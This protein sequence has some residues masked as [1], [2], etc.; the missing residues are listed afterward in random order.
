MEVKETETQD[1]PAE[2]SCKTSTATVTRWTRREPPWTAQDVMES[3]TQVLEA[4]PCT[5]CLTCAECKCPRKMSKALLRPISSSYPFQRLHID[6]IGPLP[7]TKRG[8]RYI[9]TVQCS[10][11]KWVKAYAIPNQRAKTCAR[12]LMDNLGL[13]IWCPRFN[14]FRPPPLW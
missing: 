1:R 8:N 6:I 3:P 10:F 13:L 9:L 12:A 2:S 11:T 5:T 14:P 4:W 7:R